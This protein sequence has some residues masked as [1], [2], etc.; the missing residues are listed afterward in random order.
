MA[1]IMF[2]DNQ[3]VITGKIATDF[4]KCALCMACVKTCPSGARILPPPMSEKIRQMLSKFK[5][6]RRENETYI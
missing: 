2:D 4:T 1:Y 3:V 5:G 6:L